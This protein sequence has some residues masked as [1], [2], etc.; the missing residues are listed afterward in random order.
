MDVSQPSS[1]KKIEKGKLLFLKIQLA[2]TDFLRG[3]EADRRWEAP[4]A[5][6]PQ[7]ASGWS[8][9]ALL[10]RSVASRL[11]C[12]SWGRTHRLCCGLPRSPGCGLERQCQLPRASHRV[13]LSDGGFGHQIHFL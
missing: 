13:T 4:S 6:G 11:P 12:H 7:M 9:P 1:A 5:G 8:G 10:L 2:M 3:G